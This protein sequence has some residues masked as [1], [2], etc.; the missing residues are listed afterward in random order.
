MA[1]AAP[2]AQVP[3]PRRAPWTWRLSKRNLTEAQFI[4]GMALAFMAEEQLDSRPFGTEGL[5]LNGAP[6]IITAASA[7]SGSGV[8]EVVLETIAEALVS[9]GVDV[10]IR[11]LFHCE[12]VPAK[13]KW[14]LARP[15]EDEEENSCIFDDISD[16]SLASG[17][18]SCA[19]HGQANKTTVV[20]NGKKK[21]KL[22]QCTVEAAEIFTCGSSCRYFSHLS[23]ARRPQGR[24]ASALQRLHKLAAQ[25]AGGESNS[26]YKTWKGL[27]DYI[28]VKKPKL[29]LWENTDA[30]TDVDPDAAAHGLSF[31][32]GLGFVLACV[33][34][35]GYRA[36]AFRAN[37]MDYGLPQ[38]RVRVYMLAVLEE[39]P[40]HNTK[41]EAQW[42]HFWS[43]VAEEM[44]EIKRQPPCSAL[45]F[46]CA[47]LARGSGLDGP[48]SRV[49]VWEAGLGYDAGVGRE[50]A[51]SWGLMNWRLADGEKGD[52]YKAM[53]PDDY[54]AVA[55]ELRR[56]EQ[57]S[58]ADTGAKKKKPDW[59]EL[60]RREYLKIGLRWG[61][62]HDMHPGEEIAASPWYAVLPPREKEALLYGLKTIGENATIDTSQSIT[63]LQH[64]KDV[65]GIEVLPTICPK[66][67]LFVPFPLHTADVMYPRPLIGRELMML[68]GFPTDEAFEEQIENFKGQLRKSRVECEVEPTLS[69]MAGNMFPATV[70]QALLM[71]TFLALPWAAAQRDFG[72]FEQ[73]RA[74]S[75]HCHARAL[76]VGVSHAATRRARV[77]PGGAIKG[78]LAS[79]G[80]RPCAPTARARAWVREPLAKAGGSQRGGAEAGPGDDNEDGPG[81]E[82][83]L[84]DGAGPGDHDPDSE[85]ASESTGEAFVSE[86]V[87]MLQQRPA[88]A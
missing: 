84:G 63:R 38:S 24:P 1:Q 41:N 2:P 77:P 65:N 47:L 50:A 78:A 18:C 71:S 7:C 10:E 12:I 69:D 31:E 54:H 75:A 4:E 46:A 44:R 64:S 85:D 80:S 42:S 43:T 73:A 34:A 33:E 62:P 67:N 25:A 66:M 60:H 83:G 88:A 58:Q 70:V 26:S 40:W 13:Q 61:A 81:D 57:V 53:L 74:S 15:S 68:Q 37:S 51:G 21:V 79:G 9:R 5:R 17:M 16:L 20:I 82:A 3:G 28:E 49:R 14:L 87:A 86:I 36:M 11:H 22:G 45:R 52:F 32:S 72:F 8:D 76:V 27:Q 19:R 35:A 39:S 55:D 6:H 23:R 48:G 29:V 30:V 56:R 59:P